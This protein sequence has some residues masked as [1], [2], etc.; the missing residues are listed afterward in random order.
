MKIYPNKKVSWVEFYS[1]FVAKYGK[2]EA[3][4]AKFRIA[5]EELNRTKIKMA[6]EG[7]KVSL[8]G[9]LGSIVISLVH[10]GK[11]IFINHSATAKKKKEIL[12]RGGT[13]YK[14]WKDENGNKQNNG[15]EEYLIF[16]LKDNFLSWRWTKPYYK[17]GDTRFYF[18]YE[19]RVYE[20]NILKKNRSEFAKK[21]DGDP[22][23]RL[24]IKLKGE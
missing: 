10:M 1:A 11:K 7:Q 8:G 17:Q 6:T 5:F 9:R 13:L 3:S 4:M 22:E 15:G 20:L 24:S 12:S 23:V 21:Y 14:E 18:L 16:Y 19:A 2:N